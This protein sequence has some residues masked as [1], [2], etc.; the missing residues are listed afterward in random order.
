MRYHAS[1]TAEPGKAKGEKREERGG[2]RQ[3]KEC[4]QKE[5]RQRI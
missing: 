2:G 3:G 5:Q 1:H 4:I